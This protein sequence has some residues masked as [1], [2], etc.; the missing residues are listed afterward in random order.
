MHC[1]TA[2]FVDCHGQN[3]PSWVG[4]S[5]DSQAFSASGADVDRFEFA[6]LNTLHDGLAGHAVGEGGLQHCQPAVGGLACT[7]CCF[8]VHLEGT[9]LG[10]D[11]VQC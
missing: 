4:G 7:L 11:V 9:V 8:F 3:S 1:H 6:A 10:A 5:M 2:P